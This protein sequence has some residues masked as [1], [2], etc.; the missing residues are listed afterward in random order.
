MALLQI[1]KKISGIY[2]HL[3]QACHHLTIKNNK[4]NYKAFYT[5]LLYYNTR[6]HINLNNDKHNNDPDFI[7][8][9]QTQ[10]II[11]KE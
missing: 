2:K 1:V 5:S 10:Y 8:I 9:I 7:I 6:C 3:K 4:N 11:I